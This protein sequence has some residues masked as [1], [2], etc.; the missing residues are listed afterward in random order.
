MGQSAINQEEALAKTSQACPSRKEAQPPRTLQAAR[1]ELQV[2]FGLGLGLQGGVAPEKLNLPLAVDGPGSWNRRQQRFGSTVCSEVEH[3]TA[4]PRLERLPWR[5]REDGSPGEG[6][7]SPEVPPCILCPHDANS[8]S[9]QLQLAGSRAGRAKVQGS[10]AKL[11]T[12]PVRA[13]RVYIMPWLLHAQVH[14]ISKFR[15]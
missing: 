13:K 2:E 4:A 6:E 1:V 5:S 15:S 7:V 14:L 12:S 3:F 8:I 10:S 11:T 9:E